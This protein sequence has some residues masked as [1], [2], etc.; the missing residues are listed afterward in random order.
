LKAFAK[1]G[2]WPLE[3]G[4]V[5]SI[6]TRPV[7]PPPVINSTQ[8]IEEIKTP[9]SAKSI[10]HFQNDYRKN[11]TKLKLEKLFKANIKLSIQ[12]ELD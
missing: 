7:T 9:K 6:I 8:L 1:P 2:I 12:A 10:R 5:L 4:I 11:P 3:P